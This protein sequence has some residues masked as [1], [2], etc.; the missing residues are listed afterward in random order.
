M[1]LAHPRNLVVAEDVKEGKPGKSV[2]TVLEMASMD[3]DESRSRM[4]SS[5]T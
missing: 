1:K 5:R 4:L 2:C 3:S